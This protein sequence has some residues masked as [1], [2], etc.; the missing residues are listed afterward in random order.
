MNCIILGNDSY[1]FENVESRPQ[2]YQ[3][4]FGSNRK[5]GIVKS[6][7]TTNNKIW[8]NNSVACLRTKSIAKWVKVPV[9]LDDGECLFR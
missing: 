7:G 4:R 1:N 3:E 9:A 8:M 5:C 2:D 6:Q